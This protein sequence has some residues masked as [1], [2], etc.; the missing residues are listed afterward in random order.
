MEGFSLVFSKVLGRN[1]LRAEV[2]SWCRDG[3]VLGPDYTY[4]S[5]VMWHMT[6]LAASR[7]RRC[8]LHHILSSRGVMIYLNCIYIGAIREKS[9]TKPQTRRGM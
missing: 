3:Y 2:R 8:S 6:Y 1:R 4:L 5:R 7:R 9:N